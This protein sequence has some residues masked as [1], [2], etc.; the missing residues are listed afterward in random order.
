MKKFLFIPIALTCFAIVGFVT[1]YMM[2]RSG[3]EINCTEC[4]CPEAEIYLQPFDDFSKEEATKLVLVLQT[5][6]D[7]L[8]YGHWEFRV[9]DPIALPKER[10]VDNKHHVTPILNLEASKLKG[11][12][13]IIGLTHQDISADIHQQKNYGIVGMS[14]PGQQVCLVSDKRVKNKSDYWKP[15][16]HEFI[17]TFYNA[18][19]CPKDDPKCIMKD[20]K[21]HGNFGVQKNLCDACKHN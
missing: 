8:I 4:L 2:N 5:H 9:L 1:Y 6:F 14:R 7:E 13:I 17:H 16:L 18:N 15:I 3:E 21:G 10:V 20:A 12:E 19:H 11:K